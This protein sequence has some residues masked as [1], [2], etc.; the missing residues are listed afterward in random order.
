M[1]SVPA[2][3]IPPE[4]HTPKDPFPGFLH[5]IVFMKCMIREA[6]RD[7]GLQRAMRVRR[8]ARLRE[9]GIY[10]E[11]DARP[12]GGHPEPRVRKRYRPTIERSGWLRWTEAIMDNGRWRIVRRFR[13]FAK[14]LEYRRKMREDDPSAFDWMIDVFVGDGELERRKHVR[15]AY[16]HH[17]GEPWPLWRLHAELHHIRNYG[18]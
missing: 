15:V 14:I 7:A 4:K 1:D 17:F 8:T 11:F 18:D 6:H 13:S 2:S 5:Y 10:T 16:T 3:A 9:P 12:V